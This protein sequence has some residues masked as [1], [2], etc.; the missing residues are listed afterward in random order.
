M[1]HVCYVLARLF[2]STCH[3]QT[4]HSIYC[5]VMYIPIALVFED[6][7]A[8]SSYT[9]KSESATPWQTVSDQRALSYN[10]SWS[11]RC[12][13][14]KSTV[15]SATSGHLQQL[16]DSNM[17]YRNAFTTWS[18]LALLALFIHH[19]DL[20][21]L[22][23]S[24][25]GP[26]P[27]CFCFC[28][29]STCSLLTCSLLFICMCMYVTSFVRELSQYTCVYSIDKHAHEGL[30]SAQ[31]TCPLQCLSMMASHIFMLKHGHAAALLVPDALYNVYIA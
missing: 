23:Y 10:N 6:M 26:L 4:L 7:S 24:P 17:R 9:T 1:S 28:R 29:C 21:V 30:A 14:Q 20:V 25:C 15:S 22:Q 2:H 8:Y 18:M 3:T 11:L 16:N 19:A 5:T 12:K 31:H 27:H 13:H